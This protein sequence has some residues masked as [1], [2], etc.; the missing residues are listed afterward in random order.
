MVRRAQHGF[1]LV[2]LMVVLAI[3]VILAGVGI[4]SFKELIAKQRLR[5][6]SAELYAA[7]T[8]TRSEAVKLNRDVTLSPATGGWTNGWTI[9]NPKAGT[10]AFETHAAL[11]NVTVTSAAASVVFG[12]NGRVKATTPPTFALAATGTTE[13]RCIG[14]DLSGRPYQKTVTC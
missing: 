7:L 3:M 1:T 11:V 6:A 5:G 10:N 9:A 12:S 14:L 8:R 2:E 4:P 13:V